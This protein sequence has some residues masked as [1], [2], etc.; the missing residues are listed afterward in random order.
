MEP[1]TVVIILVV[2]VGLVVVGYWLLTKGKPSDGAEREAEK[3]TSLD[4]GSSATR[5]PKAQDKKTADAKA[6]GKKEPTHKASEPRTDRGA[7]K[8]RSEKAGGEDGQAAGGTGEHAKDGSKRSEAAAETGRDA[9]KSSTEGA[10]RERPGQ[11]SASGAQPAKK[12]PAASEDDD[13]KERRKALR[14][15][16]K[17][18]RGGF[19]A[20]LGNLLHGK[21]TIDPQLLEKIEEIL[22]TADVG[23]QFTDKLVKSMKENLSG[24]ELENPGVVW[25][26]MRDQAFA[27]LTP[28][29]RS[30]DIE[31]AHPFVIMVIGVNGVGKTTTIAKLAS[32]YVKD[33][34]KVVLAAGDTFRAAAVRQLEMWGARVGAEVVKNDKQGADPSAVTFEAIE[35]GVAQGADIVIADT[36]GRLHTKTPLMEELKKVKRVM[37]KAMDGAPHEVL[38]VLDANTGQ[39]AIQQV[40]E[41]QDALGITGIVL[42]K[43]DGTAKGGVILGICEE[44]RIP[45]RFIG[46][47]ERDDDLRV[48]D[49]EDFVAVLFE[50][51]DESDATAA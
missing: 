32:R 50:G 3:K 10:P 6:T 8:E 12:A 22:L 21:K 1:T 13:R 28:D 46:V 18:T 2:L 26:F 36:A 9:E 38:L 40:R 29:A 47:G 35:K 44:H 42:T 31:S 20:S 15:G 11:G 23:V 33:G 5:T 49:A 14:R 37:G 16:L 7:T 30:F 43:L 17:G 24:K 19:I 4:T 25:S 41:F 34:K 39:N 48:F 51:P 45:V 27:I